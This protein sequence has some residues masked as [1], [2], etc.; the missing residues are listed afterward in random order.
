MGDQGRRREPRCGD[1]SLVRRLTS[2]TAV[3]AVALAA[4]V[5]VGPPAQASTA[6]S[7]E[8]L[9]NS[10]RV[11]AGLAPYAVSSDLSAVALAQAKRMAAAQKL[12]HNP[13]LATAV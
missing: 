2:S 3:L 12:Y 11:S 7:F 13:G 8:S 1:M 6:S 9:T 4:F 10:A 5:A